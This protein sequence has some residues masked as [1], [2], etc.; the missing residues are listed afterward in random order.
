M[1]GSFIPSRNWYQFAD[2][3]MIT[4]LVS[5]GHVDR[6][7]GSNSCIRTPGLRFRRANHYTIASSSRGS[8]RSPVFSSFPTWETY[9]DYKVV[10]FINYEKISLNRSAVSC[11]S[12]FICCSISRIVSFSSAV[13]FEAT[14][15]SYSVNKVF[16]FTIYKNY[17]IKYK[18]YNK[19]YKMK[20]P[21]SFSE[22]FP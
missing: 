4:G 5:D 13:A 9:I 3:E 19:V 6:C 11:S 1:R 14:T 16:K 20:N 17:Y 15:S 12:Y 7:Q 2:P 22:T 21:S 18:Y 10:S 8:P